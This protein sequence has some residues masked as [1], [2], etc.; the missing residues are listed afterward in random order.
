MPLYS[1]KYF[2][3][4]DLNNANEF[5]EADLKLRGQHFEAVI[6]IIGTKPINKESIQSIERY[7]DDLHDHEAEIKQLLRE[8]FKKEGV[9]Y[10]YID[11]QVENLNKANISKLIEGI[12]LK[13][14]KKE[15]LFSVVHLL[16][17][18][19]YPDEDDPMFAMH[20]FT[21]NKDLTDDLLAVKLYKD[22]T[23]R[24]DIES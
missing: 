11:L 21:I 3:D 4:I 13:L 23:V 1:T 16:T 8:D 6:N 2:G 14:N 18:N 7:L 22:N 10:E 19:F 17:I 5:Y 20:D 9:V 12:K 24:I 15:K